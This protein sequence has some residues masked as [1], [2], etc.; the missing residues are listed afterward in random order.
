[1]SKEGCQRSRAVGVELLVSLMK[2]NSPPHHYWPPWTPLTRPVHCKQAALS[3]NWKDEKLTLEYDIL[4]S[5]NW[6][7]DLDFMESSSDVKWT[8]FDVDRWTGAARCTT[9]GRRTDIRPWSAAKSTRINSAVIIRA[10]VLLFSKKS[11][12]TRSVF[13]RATLC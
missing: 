8:Y 4:K 12:T 7:T 10:N 2:R 1:M 6:S 9:H 3:L 13:T 11:T 5:D